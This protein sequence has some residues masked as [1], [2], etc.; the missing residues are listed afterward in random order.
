MKVVCC[1]GY[2]DPVHPG[3]RS[4]FQAARALGDKLVV[5]THPDELCIKKKGFCY[6]KLHD[7]IKALMAEPDV[8][9]VVVSIDSDGT[10]AKTLRL[11]KPQ[12][13][14]KGG[15]R[16]PDQHPIPQAEV[17]AC[18]EIGCTIVYNVGEPKRPGWSST[19]I[20]KKALGLE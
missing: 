6:E 8:D 18:A 2:F 20:G 11:L 3:H 10:V 14:C 17:D 12:L 7:R 4:H 19:E 15:D 13:F 5:I 1:C 9:E 16:S